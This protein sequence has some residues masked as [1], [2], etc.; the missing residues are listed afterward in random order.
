MVPVDVDQAGWGSQQIYDDGTRGRIQPRYIVPHWGGTTA[1]VP[2]AVEADRLRGWQ[3]YHTLSRGMQDIAYNYAIGD[4]GTIYRCRGLNPGGH[5]KSTDDTPEGDPYNLASIG[6]VWIG[7][8]RAG[9]PSD[10]AFDAMARIIDATGWEVV[11]HRTAKQQNGSSTLCPGDDWL[12]W[13][14]E[15]GWD[16]MPREQ[17]NR[18][19]RA[20]F[21][22]RPDEFQGDPNYF[23]NK[24]TDNPPGIAD[25]LDSP[26][27]GDDA[28]NGFWPA[29]TRAISLEE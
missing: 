12:Q 24:S 25:Q 8:Q 16:T 28:G 15:K 3:R 20:L 23:I 18:M 27:W 21:A 9:T 7:G 14:T 17:W 29:F 5:T 19:I 4:S 22:G 13:I 10:A 1:Y 2:P 26:D 6:V 11:G